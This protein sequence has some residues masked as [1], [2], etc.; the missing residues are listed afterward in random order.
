MFRQARRESQYTRRAPHRSAPGQS[1]DEIKFRLTETSWDIQLQNLVVSE[2]NPEG[3]WKDLDNLGLGN[4]LNIVLDYS[5][6]AKY[7][8][9]P[10]APAE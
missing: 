4:D 3:E 6:P 1:T 7:R 5:D 2:E 9:T 8:W 10:T